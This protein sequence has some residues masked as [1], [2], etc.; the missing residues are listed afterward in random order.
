MNIKILGD[1][2]TTNLLLRFHPSGN[3]LR[4]QIAI[5]TINCSNT[6]H[7]NN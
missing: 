4:G 7:T 5:D 2:G 3:I 6:L 1:L